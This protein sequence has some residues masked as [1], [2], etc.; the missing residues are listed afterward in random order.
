MEFSYTGTLASDGLTPPAQG[1]EVVPERLFL[2]QLLKG[3][4]VVAQCGSQAPEEDVRLLATARDRGCL[5][6]L[7]PRWS[8]LITFHNRAN[9]AAEQNQAEPV[10]RGPEAHSNQLAA[11]WRAGRSRHCTSTSFTRRSQSLVE[12]REMAFWTRVGLNYSRAPLEFR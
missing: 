2:S 9:A 7:G 4:V 3:G 8:R 10:A 5:D 1:Y 11:A 6:V 12:R